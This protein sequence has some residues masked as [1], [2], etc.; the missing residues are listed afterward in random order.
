VLTARAVAL[1]TTLALSAAFGGEFA[2]DSSTPGSDS[3]RAQRLLSGRFPAQSGDTVQVVVHADDVT[4]AAVRGR[5]DTLLD[6]LERMPIVAAVEDPYVTD[7]SVTPDRRI[8][9]ARVYLDVINPT[10]CRSGTP[11][12]CWPPRRRPS[13]TR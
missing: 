6:E 2:T 8:L 12:G 4:A 1:A 9:V 10:T 3:E 11:N 5:V 13:G 7:G